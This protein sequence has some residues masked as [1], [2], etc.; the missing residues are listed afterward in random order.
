L[1]ARLCAITSASD[2][3]DRRPATGSGHSAIT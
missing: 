2:A 3:S 1:H